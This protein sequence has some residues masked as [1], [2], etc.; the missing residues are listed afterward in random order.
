MRMVIMPALGEWV[1]IHAEWLLA[2]DRICRLNRHRMSICME[3]HESHVVMHGGTRSPCSERAMSPCAD[4]SS[5]LP[6]MCFC[7][8]TTAAEKGSSSSGSKPP[9]PPSSNGR[10]T[11]A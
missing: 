11:L 5:N 4:L 10:R 3:G 9:T 6:C 7:C 8:S 2:L 1:V